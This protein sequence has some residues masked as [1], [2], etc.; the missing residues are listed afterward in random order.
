[1]RPKYNLIY[2]LFFPS[3]PPLLISVTSFV[4]IN[5]NAT[6]LSIPHSLDERPGVPLFLHQ[7][8]AGWPFPAEDYIEGTLDLRRFAVWNRALSFFRLVGLVYL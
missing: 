1:M 8:V 2:F 4:Y 6:A 7:V 3:L 5:M